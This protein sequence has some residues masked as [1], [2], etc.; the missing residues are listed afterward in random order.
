MHKKELVLQDLELLKFTN[1]NSDYEKKLCELN[2]SKIY[3]SGDIQVILDADL[4]FTVRLDM[5]LHIIYSYFYSTYNLKF[6]LPHIQ[7]L[8]RPNIKEGEYSSDVLSLIF[9]ELDKQNLDGYRLIMET[10]TKVFKKMFSEEYLTLMERNPQ[11]F[12]KLLS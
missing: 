8:D 7:E 12:N 9:R 11:F 4:G 3:S 6:L 2:L 10:F 5:I 1:P